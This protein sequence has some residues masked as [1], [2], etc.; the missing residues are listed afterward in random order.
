MANKKY[1]EIKRVTGTFPS[2]RY[3]VSFETLSRQQK[4]LLIDNPIIRERCQSDQFVHILFELCQHRNTNKQD[5]RYYYDWSTGD[6]VQLQELKENYNTIDWVCAISGKPIRAKMDDFNPE[7]FIHPEY[8]D[9]L[10]APMIDS[11]I[12]KSSIEFRKHIKKLLLNQQQEF[13][14]L[15]KKNSKYNL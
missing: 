15:A 13:I 10:K 12:L 11:Q 3:G 1:P 8:L 4:R 14:N 2:N 9:V 7:N 6:F 5:E